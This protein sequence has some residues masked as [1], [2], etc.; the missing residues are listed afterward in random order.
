MNL[1][2]EE[3]SFLYLVSTDSLIENSCLMKKPKLTVLI[4][5]YKNTLQKSKYDE[6]I[7][8]ACE[9]ACQKSV[10]ETQA[11]EGT[12]VD[13]FKTIKLIENE[14]LYLNEES[15]GKDFL[16]YNITYNL[17][18]ENNYIIHYD[19]FSL[20]PVKYIS[21]SNTINLNEL[22]VGTKIRI[23][24]IIYEVHLIK[25]NTYIKTD[26]FSYVINVNQNEET[27]CK[28]CLSNTKND[29]W[30]STCKCIGSVKYCH[31]LCL[32]NWIKQKCGVN[33][34][35]INEYEY[36]MELNKFYCEICKVA[37]PF[38]VFANEEYFLFL[39]EELNPFQNCIIL[40][41][42]TKLWD[43]NNNNNNHNDLDKKQFCIFN[44][45]NNEITLGRSS[46]CSIKINDQSIS[47]KHCSITL[48]KENKKIFIKDLNSK[49][50]T[51][52]NNYNY[53]TDITL[54]NTN[55]N[56]VIQKGNTLYN[57]KYNYN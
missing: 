28:I 9:S 53:S 1:H 35:E 49:Y 33:S 26:S 25:I 56:I 31:Y 23:G 12:F 54:N 32:S 13:N 44:F 7:N 18:K 22:K 55:N 46:V 6:Y 34:T 39:I 15:G 38:G 48:H 41:K 45:K 51:L 43:N 20:F 17:D 47:K 36:T 37:Y 42:H 19:H 30:I 4:S 57:F 11:N 52:I 24:Q 21:S 16:Q 10:I 14:Q 3:T 27:K 29:Y 40:S 2:K 50:G 5:K 8:Y